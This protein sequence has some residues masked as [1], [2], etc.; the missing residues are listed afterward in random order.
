MG[1]ALKRYRQRLRAEGS[2]S[3]EEAAE[4]PRNINTHQIPAGVS[5]SHVHPL[6]FLFF[7]V[8][9]LLVL[10]GGVLVVCVVVLVGALGSRRGGDGREGQHGESLAELL[11]REALPYLVYGLLWG[12]FLLLL[13]LVGGGGRRRGVAEGTAPGPRMLGLGGRVVAR[14]ITVVHGGGGVR[15]DSA[16]ERGSMC[17]QKKERTGRTGPRRCAPRIRR[18]PRELSSWEGGVY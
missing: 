12:Q 3:A 16:D 4:E 8:F 6:A 18:W 13:L 15:R 9:L 2:G 10:F 11:L 14:L 1:G 5:I 7:L 17:V